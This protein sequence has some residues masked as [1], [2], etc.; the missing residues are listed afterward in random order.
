MFN[1]I[2]NLLSIK[3]H[4]PNQEVKTLSGGNQQKVSLGKWFGKDAKIWIFDEP[5]QGIDIDS[6]REIYLIMQRLAKEGCGIWFISS[7][8]RELTAICDRIYI[9]KD[10]KIVTEFK[11]PYERQKILSSMLGGN[12]DG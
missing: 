10:F 9:M 12:K 3:I 2:V 7:D 11:A 8:L 5:T 6:K 1:N 4:S